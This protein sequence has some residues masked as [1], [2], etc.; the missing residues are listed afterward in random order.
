[1]SHLLKSQGVF[2][3]NK[4]KNREV[5]IALK[6]STL[7]SLVNDFLKEKVF[8]SGMIDRKYNLR[9]SSWNAP[10]ET[11]VAPVPLIFQVHSVKIF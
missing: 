9:H 5:L 4:N 2:F 6:Y 1:M 7:S 3:R 8:K 11:S 10:I